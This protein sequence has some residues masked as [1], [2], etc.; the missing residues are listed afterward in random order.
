M[1][2]MTIRPLAAHWCKYS[3]KKKVSKISIPCVGCGNNLVS[4]QPSAPGTHLVQHHYVS[5]QEKV[6][7]HIQSLLLG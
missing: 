6:A 7:R 3:T 4:I 2:R 1:V 5:I